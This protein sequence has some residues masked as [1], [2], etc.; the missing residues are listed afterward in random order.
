MYT[1]LSAHSTVL[2]VVPIDTSFR[3]T[4]QQTSEHKGHTVWTRLSEHGSIH[5]TTV[6]VHTASCIG[7][8][9]C[10]DVCPTR[11]FVP[12]SSE[13]GMRI[14]DP[15]N[16]D[17]CIHCIVCE[18]VCPTRAIHVLMEYGSQDTLD[19]LLRSV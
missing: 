15:E 1:S 14:V 6:A 13:S 8:M 4:W 3:K 18:M 11:V 10:I 16:E 2:S 5:G 12:W 19:S 7:C 17:N 9:K